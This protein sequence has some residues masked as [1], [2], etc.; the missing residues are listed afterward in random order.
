MLLPNSFQQDNKIRAG[1]PVRFPGN[2]APFQFRMKD[3]G[4]ETITAVCATQANGGDRIQHDFKKNQFTPVQNY[5]N[6]VARSIA[7]VPANSA[8][9]AI[10]GVTN[11]GAAAV[12]G[13][14]EPPPE[15]SR[16][17]FRAAIRV[18]VR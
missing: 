18:P 12:G 3:R 15:N 6:S 9:A 2:N 14:R 4:T 10:S 13:P 8:P 5:T 16:A 7:I 11:G 17:S 1:V